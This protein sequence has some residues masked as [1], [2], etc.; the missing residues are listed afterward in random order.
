MFALVSF[1]ICFCLAKLFGQPLNFLPVTLYRPDYNEICGNS[2]TSY[3]YYDIPFCGNAVP[4]NSAQLQVSL[5]VPDNPDFKPTPTN[6]ICIQLSTCKDDFSQGCVFATNY[7]LNETD[8]NYYGYANLVID[9]DKFCA[10]LSNCTV[11]MRAMAKP[12]SIQYS[13]QLTFVSSKA[14]NY[15]AF[16][17]SYPWNRPGINNGVVMQELSQYWQ[18]DQIYQTSVNEFTYFYIGHCSQTAPVKEIEI[19]VISPINNTITLLQTFACPKSYGDYTKCTNVVAPCLTKYIAPFVVLTCSN[20]DTQLD[21]GIYVGVQTFGNDPNQP[22][23]FMFQ[24]IVNP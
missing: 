18:S 23:E 4:P 13:V 8:F 16:K 12:N 15:L 10:D 5:E 3:D 7:V 17:D 2:D 14:E 22:N 9:T 24:A 20:T 21:D 11:Y 19:A 1:I 6:L